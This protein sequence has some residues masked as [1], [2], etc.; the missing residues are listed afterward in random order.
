MDNCEPTCF[1]NI[2]D[3]L[4]SRSKVKKIRRSL[5]D[6]NRMFDYRRGLFCDSDVGISRLNDALLPFGFGVR[7]RYGP[8]VTINDL[9]R[10]TVDERGSYPIVAVG[11]AYFGEQT[12]SYKYSGDPHVDHALVVLRVDLDN[13]RVTFFDPY[14]NYLKAKGITDVKTELPIVRFN[15][16]WGG[17][18]RP[19]WMA[20]VEP[21]T[22]PIEEWRTEQGGTP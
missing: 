9:L 17:A 5:G 3:E 19:Y 6:L 20:W 18:D 2:L 16:Y 10:V 15:S 21:V 1:K 8:Q 22:P 7:K 12:K 13:Q 4:S 11:Q 14:E